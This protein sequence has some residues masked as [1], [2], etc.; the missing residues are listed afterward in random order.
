MKSVKSVDNTLTRLSDNRSHVP[1][2]TDRLSRS[3][4]RPVK[5]MLRGQ[6]SQSE[7]GRR[8]Q[9]LPAGLSFGCVRLRW[10]AIDTPVP[11]QVVS[12]WVLFLIGVCRCAPMVLVFRF[13]V[14]P[15]FLQDPPDALVSLVVNSPVPLAFLGA[16]GGSPPW[17]GF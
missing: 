9:R 13:R 2:V 3:R 8:A 14:N 10:P 1:I 6:L 4:G 12:G 5:S 16:L 17:A 7:Q 15:W 11:L